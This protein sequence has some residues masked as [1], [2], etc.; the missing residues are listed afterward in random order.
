MDI[1]PNKAA[2]YEAAFDDYMAK[3]DRALEQSRQ[4]HVRIQ[5]LKTETRAILAGLKAEM[6][7]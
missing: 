5:E 4:E 2:K 6:R 1:P 3:I 7:K